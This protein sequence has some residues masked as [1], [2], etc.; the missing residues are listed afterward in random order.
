VSEDPRDKLL[1]DWAAIAKGLQLYERKG[2]IADYDSELAGLVARTA[3]A[4]LEWRDG[5]GSWPE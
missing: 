5:P 3:R 2:E 1:R 4:T